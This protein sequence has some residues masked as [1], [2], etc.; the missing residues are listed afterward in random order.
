M[1][2][3]MTCMT[4]QDPG[5][6]TQSGHHFKDSL[7]IWTRNGKILINPKSYMNA[8]EKFKPDMYYFLSDGDTNICSAIK[9]VNKAVERTLLFFREC[10]ERHKQSAVL[11]NSFAMAP[12]SGGYCLKA[13]ERCINEVLKADEWISGYLIDGLHNNGPEVEFLKLA[14]IKPVVELV[15]VSTW[16]QLFAFFD[17]LINL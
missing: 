13:R 3:C 15:I 5:N 9:R 16:K 1:K 8:V 4:L 7:P 17:V 10:L 11:K 14:E 12:I 2:D 6:L